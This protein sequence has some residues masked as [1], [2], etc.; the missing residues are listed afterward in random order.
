[1]FQLKC[2]AKCYDWGR[3]GRN[4]LAAN[5]AEAG[6]DLIVENDKPYAELWMGSHTS[7]P[8]FCK[9]SGKPLS[10]ILDEKT[11]GPR[12]FEV[13]GKTLPF[14]F[15]VLSIEKVLSIQAHPDKQLGKKLHALAPEHYKDDNHKP[16]MAIALTDF[17]ALCGFRPVE[18]LIEFLNNIPALNEFVGQ[19]AVDEFFKSY[20]QDQRAA[21]KNLFNVVMRQSNDRIAQYTDKL[22]AAAEQNPVDFGGKKFGG[23]SLANL[24]VRLNKQFPHDIGLFVTLFLNYVSLRPGQAVFLRALDPHAYVSG[25]IIECM[26]ASD[27]VIRVGFT[28]KY[29]DVNTLVENLTYQ[30]ANA[31]EQLTIPVPF[32]GANGEGKTLLYDPP[33][34]EFSI[35][36]TVVPN[37]K[38]QSVSSIKGPSIVLTTEGNGSIVGKDGSEISLSPGTVVFVS[39]DYDITFTASSDLTVYQA[40]CSI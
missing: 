5:F 29:K 23:N 14:L 20:K 37:G 13:Y 8:S 34:E 19:E 2:E 21:L 3:V 33:I 18:Q 22:V 27:N 36:Q 30:T 40:F 16:E 32:A 26:A 31:E 15:K 17:S 4:S 38:K 7:G 9:Q 24:I 12:I 10:E 39:A 11:M 35:L 28:P 6:S 25:N 1:M